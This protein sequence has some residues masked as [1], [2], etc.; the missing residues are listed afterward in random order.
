M[1]KTLKQKY[2]T[3]KEVANYFW[4]SISS[5]IKLIYK[6]WLKEN[7]MTWKKGE[8]WN[9]IIRISQDTIDKLEKKI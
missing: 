8:W 9:K 3:R 5:L 6:N 4:I 7:K 2:F 1:K